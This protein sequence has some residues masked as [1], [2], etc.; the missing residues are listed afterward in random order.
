MVPASRMTVIKYQQSTKFT[1]LNYL[2]LHFRSN[3]EKM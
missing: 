2:K 1:D 3:V